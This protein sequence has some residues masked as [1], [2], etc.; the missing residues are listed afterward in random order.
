MNR[1][2]AAAVVAVGLAVAWFTISPW[3]AGGVA[4]VAVI[5]LIANGGFTG[6]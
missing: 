1:Y 4:I 5:A 6:R 3:L 2:V